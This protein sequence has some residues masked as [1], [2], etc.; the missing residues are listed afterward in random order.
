[1]HDRGKLR[2]EVHKCVARSSR[3][4]VGNQA[5]DCFVIV[6]CRFGHSAKLTH[7]LF[8][9]VEEWNQANNQLQCF[10]ALFE[11][12]DLPRL[13]PSHSLGDS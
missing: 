13:R 8:R 1:M 6:P 5:C 3:L 9:L 7:T 10:V 4:Q 11:F 2:V 12:R